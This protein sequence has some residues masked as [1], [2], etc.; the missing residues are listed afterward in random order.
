MT[1]LP[2]D[3]HSFYQQMVFLFKHIQ[4][5]EYITTNSNFIHRW[6]DLFAYKRS[7]CPLMTCLS[8]DDLS[9]QKWPLCQKNDLSVQ[10]HTEYITMHSNFILSRTAM[11]SVDTADLAKFG[12]P[13]Y[14]KVLILDKVI[15]KIQAVLI[16]HGH[17]TYNIG[18]FTVHNVTSGFCRFFL[19]WLF[20]PTRSLWPL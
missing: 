18:P 20:C 6:P 12:G 14:R 13:F 2:T 15:M 19:F 4:N 9:V 7:F 11:C 8:T 1:F 5:T 10:A 16:H 17:Y 3:D